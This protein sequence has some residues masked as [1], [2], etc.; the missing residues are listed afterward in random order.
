[1]VDIRYWYY[2]FTSYSSYLSMTNSRVS[3][4]RIWKFG[5]NTFNT[6][7]IFRLSSLVSSWRLKEVKDAQ[8]LLW[9]L[10][11]IELISWRTQ[12]FWK[13]SLTKHF[14]RISGSYEGVLRS[15][16]FF[17]PISFFLVEIIFF[18]VYINFAYATWKFWWSITTFR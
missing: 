8:S 11:N 10:V 3:R 9:K 13:S 17:A 2:N 15:S 5:L 4:R 14:N 1:M 12:C 18:H 6:L 7:S 16:I